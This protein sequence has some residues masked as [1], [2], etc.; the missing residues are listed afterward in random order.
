MKKS[1]VKIF[2]KKF[3]RSSIE[4]ELWFYKKK[5]W[6]TVIHK[7][8]TYIL[9]VMTC[10]QFSFLVPADKVCSRPALLCFRL[11][12]TNIAIKGFFKM[13]TNTQQR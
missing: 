7:N 6:Q 11:L 13:A 10:S 12:A 3:Y 8:D 5:K 4:M 1:P 2:A 9:S